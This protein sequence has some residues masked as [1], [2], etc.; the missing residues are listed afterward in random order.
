MIWPVLR[1]AVQDNIW[2]MG[3]GRFSW[4]GAMNHI[5]Q[6]SDHYCDQTK[7]IMNSS[8]IWYDTDVVDKVHLLETNKTH[9]NTNEEDYAY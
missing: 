6:L 5:I 7:F 3:K 2:Y 9:D 1:T 8:N 4:E